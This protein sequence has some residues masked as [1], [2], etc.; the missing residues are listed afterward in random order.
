MKLK[1]VYNACYGGYGLSEKAKDMLSELKKTQREDINFEILPRYDKDLVAAVEELKG[2][3][4]APFAELQIIEFNVSS[5]KFRIEEYDGNESVVTPDSEH[6]D[7]VD[8]PEIRE[9]FPEYFL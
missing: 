3:A 1:I 6:W 5:P 9:K 4:S 8:T 2:A 7:I